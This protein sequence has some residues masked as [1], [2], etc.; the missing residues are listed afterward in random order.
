[1]KL[2]LLAVAMVGC[3]GC[4]IRPVGDEQTEAATGYRMMLSGMSCGVGFKYTCPEKAIDAAKKDC[5]K[6]GKKY[7]YATHDLG[8]V[9]YKCTPTDGQNQEVVSIKNDNK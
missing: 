4:A 3:F 7:E 1:M 9:R 2:L 8:S 5:A 6:S